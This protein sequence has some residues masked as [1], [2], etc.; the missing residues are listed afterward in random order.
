[1]YVYTCTVGFMYPTKVRKYLR[2]YF[3]KILSYFRTFVQ[4]HVHILYSS[5]DMH[6]IVVVLVVVDISERILRK[7]LKG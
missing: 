6:F 7:D 3:L 4:V 2:R 1:M 5:Y